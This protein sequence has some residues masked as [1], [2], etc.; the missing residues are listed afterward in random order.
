[1]FKQSKL[2][3]MGLLVMML[4]AFSSVGFAAAQD[5]TV[6]NESG[7]NITGF[8]V[9]PADSDSWGEDLL[10]GTPVADGEQ[11]DIVFDEADKT[12][13]WNFSIKDSAGKTW[14]WEKKEYDLT[15]I[16]KIT[17]SYKNG[18]GWLTYE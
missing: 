1:M 14:N 12:K 3:L 7:Y 10:K 5:F 11:I 16:S 17:Y 15:T 9:A 13:L 2:V 6:V 4:M 18:K 8:W